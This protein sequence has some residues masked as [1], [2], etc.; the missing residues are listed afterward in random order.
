[1]KVGII[2]VSGYTGFELIRLLINHP[3]FEIS[4]LAASSKSQIDE[5]FTQLKGVLD[6]EVNVADAKE[7]A[8]KCELV[9]LALPHKEAMKYAK[10]LLSFGVK[11]VDLSADYRLSL[12]LYE[13]NYDTHLDPKNLAHAVYGLVE[14]NRQKIKSARLIANPGCYPT[15]S[16]LATL[17]FLPYINKNLGVFIDAKSGVSGAG[18]KLVASSHFVNVNENANAYNPIKHRHADEIK[19]Q[20]SLVAN[21]EISTLFVPHLLPLTRGMLASVYAVLDEKVNK[22]FDPIAVLKQYYKDEKFIRITTSPV[23]IKNVAGTHF[24]DITAYTFEG[25]IFINSAIDNLLRGASS[26]AVANANLMCGFSEDLA[27]PKISH[28]C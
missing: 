16:L 9:F 5:V 11:V 19:E 20:L 14:L 8:Q 13:K 25:K 17:P 1:M 15:A 21:A 2:G 12:K 24:C 7:A 3:K 4:Y 27:L 6:F 10:D 28:F 26:Q 23:S 18:K 22:D